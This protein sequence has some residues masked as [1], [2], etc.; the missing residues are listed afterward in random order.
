MRDVSERVRKKMR[1]RN[2]EAR[3]VL[4]LV[5]CAALPSQ[6][7]QD[8]V[9]LAKQAGWD[10]CVIATPKAAANFLDSALLEQITG[11][12][13]RSEYKRPGEPDVLPRAD[14]LIVAP[15]TF[16]TINKWALGITDTLALGLLC[17]YTGLRKPILAVPCLLPTDLGMHPAFKKSVTLLREY[18]VSVLYEPEKYPPT[19]KV[20]GAVILEMLHTIT[21][22]YLG[23]DA[24][25]V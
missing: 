11:Y 19:N 8:V 20:P 24:R 4:Y 18:G 25:T 5:A 13:V 6:K 22:P 2:K 10:V 3:G 16:N 1:E 17:E 12:P 7:I 15:A 14:A 21:E 9:M 23:E